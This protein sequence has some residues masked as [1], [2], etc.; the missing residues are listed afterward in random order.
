MRVKTYQ[1]VVSQIGRVLGQLIDLLLSGGLHQVLL[2]LLGV[3]GQIKE[4]FFLFFRDALVVEEVIDVS[5]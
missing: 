1:R 2:V 5:I 4:R 3:G